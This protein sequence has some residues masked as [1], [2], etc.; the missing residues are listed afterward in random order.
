MSCDWPISYARCESTKDKAF[1]ASVDPETK[2]TAEVMATEL[3]NNWTGRAY[4]LCPFLVRPFKDSNDCPPDSPGEADFTR[5]T[6]GASG[7]GGGWQPA[8]IGGHWYNLTCQG[9]PGPA[10]ADPTLQAQGVKLP[11]PV[12]EVRSVWVNG[13]QL[14]RGQYILLGE[15]LYPAPGYKFP[16]HQD[17]TADYLTEEDTFAIDFVRGTPPPVGGEVAAGVLALEIMRSLCKDS[18]CKLPERVQTITRQGVTMGFVD[19]FSG[20]EEGRTGLWLVD[21]WVA[22]IKAPRRPSAVHSPD[23]S[24][25]LGRRFRF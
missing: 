25:K 12:H 2:A 23:G 4:G 11:G 8:L 15:V 6:L 14:E 1:L 18:S 19:D 16:E 22:S 7:R 24:R 21:S 13:R 20:L 17:L 5:N 10:G 3:L 9:C